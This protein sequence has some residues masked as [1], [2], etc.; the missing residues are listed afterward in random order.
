[1]NTI[2]KKLK[3]ALLIKVNVYIVKY[4]KCIFKLEVSTS[5]NCTR[6]Y[7]ILAPESITAVP[8]VNSLKTDSIIPSQNL[9]L[10][11]AKLFKERLID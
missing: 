9:S 8:N 11:V 4:L 2:I 1:M 3:L 7:C 10:T 5:V 6:A